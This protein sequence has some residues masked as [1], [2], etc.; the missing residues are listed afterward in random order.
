MIREYESFFLIDE[1][2]F[3]LIQTYKKSSHFIV[4]LKHMLLYLLERHALSFF[5]FVAS[6]GHAVAL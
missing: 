6:T 4:V 2:I 5:F 3:E 1:L